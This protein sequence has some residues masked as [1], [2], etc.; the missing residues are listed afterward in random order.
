MSWYLMPS[1]QPWYAPD[2]SSLASALLGDGATVLDEEDVAAAIAA[3]NDRVPGPA[4]HPADWATQL[5]LIGYRDEALAARDQVLEF[6]DT[7]ETMVAGFIGG[8]GPVD[9]ALTT[10]IAGD[11]PDAG[12]PIG[13]ALSATYAHLN[14]SR[15]ATKAA[16][17]AAR[18][19]GYAQAAAAKVTRFVEQWSNL[20]QWA[21][22]AG[23]V[24]V[25]GGKLYGVAGGGGANHAFRVAPGATAR[26]VFK[27]NIV[28]GGGGGVM[29][30]FNREAVGAAPTAGGPRTRGIFIQHAADGAIQV[31]PCDDFTFGSAVLTGI[32]A[33]TL[34]V[35][36]TVDE[37][38]Q[39]VSVT[40]ATGAKMWA[41][42]WLRNDATRPINNLTILMN[43][44]RGLAGSSIE[45]ITEA[46]IGGVGMAFVSGDIITPQD[47]ATMHYGSDNNDNFLI[48]CPP[49]YDSRRPTPAVLMFHGAGANVHGWYTAANEKAV[50]L[51]YLDAGFIVIAGCDA[52]TSTWG[53]DQ[54]K[55][56]YLHAYQYARDH[57]NISSWCIYAVSMGGIESLNILSDDKI[58][59]IAAWV[60]TVPAFDLAAL[61]AGLYT[62]SID[63]AYGGDYATNSVG[64]DPA[65]M[66]PWQFRGIP[67]LVLRATDDTFVTPAANSTALIAA[68]AETND[69]TVLNVTGGHNTPAIAANAA[70]FAGFCADALGHRTSWPA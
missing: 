21:L 63:A 61:H 43:D 53:N 40:S 52:S 17:D 15:L 9:A 36:F 54:G 45:P 23:S 47:S 29:I 20:S 31:L 6:G 16:Y 67:M 12:T 56:A 41:G 64:H 44:S 25:S 38:Y 8:G 65:L 37:N 7:Q 2:G 50:A 3:W 46:T 35:T 49:G 60:G 1:G 30:G 55:A 19:N 32:S 27:V 26:V 11:I 5:E 68:V 51:A 57:Y 22:V 58:P 14:R 69:V 66:D 70:A 42:H 24:Q 28:A 13:S 34:L 18:S 48:M 59:G 62:A 4:G 10:A 33:S 39:S